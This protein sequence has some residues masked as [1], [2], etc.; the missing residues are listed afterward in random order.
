MKRI[1]WDGNNIR[2]IGT[3]S[4]KID[5]V[6]CIIDREKGYCV[7]RNGKRLLHTEDIYKFWVN[8]KLHSGEIYYRNFK[9]TIKLIKTHGDYQIDPENTFY[10]HTPQDYVDERLL[11]NRIKHSGILSD[12]L[13][14]LRQDIY[15]QVTL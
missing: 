13:Y 8:S 9:E 3:L 4:I 11:S 15:Y 1:N 7:S 10:P 14:P 2:D 6:C 12:Y 5:G